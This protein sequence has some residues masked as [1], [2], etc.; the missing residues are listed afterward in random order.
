MFPLSQPLG[1]GPVRDGLLL[2]VCLHA[3]FIH[4][5]GVPM[6]AHADVRT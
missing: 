5:L 3:H 2:M 4:F 1:V 6:H